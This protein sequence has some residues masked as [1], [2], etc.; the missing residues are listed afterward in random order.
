[1]KSAQRDANTARQ[2]F[3][4]AAD[5]FPGG[6]GP[7]KFNQLEMVTTCAYRSSLVKIDARNLELTW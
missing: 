2:K 4:P 6:A 5:P 1:M 7:P 3:S